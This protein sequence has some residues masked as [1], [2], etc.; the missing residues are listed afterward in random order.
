MKKSWSA[1]SLESLQA[2]SSSAKIFGRRASERGI[3]GSPARRNSST[4]MT[5]ETAQRVSEATVDPVALKLEEFLPYRLNVCATL[6]SHALSQ[7]YADR[8]KIGVPEWRVLVTLGQ[9]GAMTAKA[10]GAHSHMHKTK[11]S[12]AVAVLGRR[13]FINRRVNRAD[14]REAFLS[15]TGAGR[16]I[17]DELTPIALDF[18]RDLLETVDASDRA[19]LDRALV[20]L[21]ERSAQLAPHIANGRRPG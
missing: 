18:A 13:K 2:A 4:E 9:F 8:Y 15:L 20:K 14:L 5:H 1:S 12:R 7:I 21:T 10:V 3:W 19:A 6:V 17:Y 16:D 11:V